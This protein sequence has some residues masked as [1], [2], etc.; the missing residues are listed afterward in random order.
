LS[1]PVTHSAAFIPARL[2][3]VRLPRKLLAP[4]GSRPALAFLLE[5]VK[6]SGIETI[7]VCTTDDPDDDELA[8]LA[9]KHRVEC[10]RGDREDIILRFDEAARHFSADLIVNVDGD[11]IFCDPVLIARTAAVL[12][13]GESD[14]VRWK[15]LPLGASPVGFTAAALSIVRKG[16]T[17]STTATGWGRF[18]TNPGLFRVAELDPPPI[19]AFSP[20]L[21]LTLDYP[22]DYMLMQAI[23]AELTPTDPNFGIDA[24]VRLVN[25]KPE[26]LDIVRG[27]NEAYWARF[28]EVA[29]DPTV[30]RGRQG[31]EES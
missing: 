26:M 25:R 2:T 5:R 28:E 18:F 3:S 29:V 24:I 27:L 14:F 19:E 6:A 30:I 1:E 31:I 8:D 11:D 17:V 7:V 13:S 22:A 12:K 4:L 9:R 16:K 20:E 10:Y 23:E 21:R 15:Q